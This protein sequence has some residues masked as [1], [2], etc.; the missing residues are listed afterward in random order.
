MAEDDRVRYLHHRGLDVQGEHHAGLVRVF[1]LFLVKVEQ[2]LAAHEHRIDDL[3]FQQRDL[4]LQDD[5]LAA[6]G[7]ELHLDVAR[8]VQRH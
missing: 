4:R 1:D 8:T 7:D 3:A 2:G 5:R 6:L